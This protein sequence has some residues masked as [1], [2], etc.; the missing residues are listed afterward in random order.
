M[1][2]RERIGLIA[3]NGIF[4]RLFA[5]AARKQGL[6]V[7][8]VAHRGETDESLA[9]HVDSLAWVRVGQIDGI[10]SALRAGGVSRAV[11]AGGIGRVKALTQARPDVGAIRIVA[12]LRSFRDDALLRAV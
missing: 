6:E 12:R 3:G 8:A 7:I 11:M 2:A 1:T 9:P 5:D 4:P 10:V